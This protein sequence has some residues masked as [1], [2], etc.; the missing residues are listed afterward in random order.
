M[1]YNKPAELEEWFVNAT[2]A[3]LGPMLMTLTSD[4]QSF[5]VVDTSPDGIATHKTYYN[6]GK[7]YV[8]QQQAIERILT[9][10]LDNAKTNN[11][12][13]QAQDLF[14]S[15][16]VSMNKFGAPRPDLG[17][18]YCENKYTLDSYMSVEVLKF[19]SQQ[20]VNAR[21]RYRRTV[22]MLGEKLDDCCKIIHRNSIFTPLPLII[23]S[24]STGAL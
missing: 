16:C 19:E 21:A 8:L 20:G 9:W 1:T 3:A 24:P 2:P 13:T 18:A 14:I 17:Q 4:P 5:T 11:T 22:G 23:Y 6:Q 7:A 12:I 15:A 10:I